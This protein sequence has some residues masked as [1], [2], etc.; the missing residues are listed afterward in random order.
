MSPDD[1]PETT[2][3]STATVATDDPARREVRVERFAATERCPASGGAPVRVTDGGDAGDADVVVAGCVRGATECAV[4]TLSTA[5]YDAAANVLTVIVGT[6]AAD[7]T[8]A[9]DCAASRP[10]LGYRV[11]VDVAE[12][13][14]GVVSVVHHDDDGRHE[15]ARRTAT[16]RPSVHTR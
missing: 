7:P 6:D 15:V 11:R 2:R 13:P 8:G 12:G 10:A 1:T 9:D 4:P 5:A 16:P 14:P 3:S